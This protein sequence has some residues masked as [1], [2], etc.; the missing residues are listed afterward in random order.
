MA[1]S[2]LRA[3]E[4]YTQEFSEEGAK[5]ARWVWFKDPIYPFSEF[6]EREIRVWDVFT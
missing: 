6:W 3:I 2:G 1:G 5:M 4:D